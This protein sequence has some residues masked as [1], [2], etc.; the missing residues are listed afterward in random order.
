M[1]V[2]KSVFTDG[3]G[4]ANPA[5]VWVTWIVFVLGHSD[6]LSDCRLVR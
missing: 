3:V 6:P 2:G 4:V 1:P 5:Q